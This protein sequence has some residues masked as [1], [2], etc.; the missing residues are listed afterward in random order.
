MHGSAFFFKGLLIGFSIAAPVG[1]IGLLCIQRTIAYGRKSGL[2]TGLGAATADG[3]YGAV[4]AFG[5]TAISSFLVGRQFWFRLV[6]GMFLFYLG[7]KAFLSRPV[8]KA[9]ASSHESLFLDY[10]STVI[11]TVTNPMTILSFAAVFAGLG[12]ASSSGG[13]ASAALMIAGV[14][15]G[16]TL[17]WFVLSAGVSLFQAK[18]ISHSLKY[19]N[20]ISGA[21]L[22]G[23]AVFA[24]ASLLRNAK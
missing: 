8:E 24:F 22:I 6:G 19:V 10:G 4:A 7:T 9:A 17:W 21:I 1:P 3:L 23:F 2:V 15:L 13:H 12:L 20:S 14:V 11:L 16:S 18:F 5:L